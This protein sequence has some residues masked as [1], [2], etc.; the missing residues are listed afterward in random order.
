L[1]IDAAELLIS[2]KEAWKELSPTKSAVG[3]GMGQ[4]LGVSTRNGEIVT[5]HPPCRSY[6][7]KPCAEKAVERHLRAIQQNLDA[8]QSGWV[9]VV[10]EGDFDKDLLRDR[11]YRY[12]LKHPG[13]ARAWYRVVKR[14]DGTR[15][16]LSTVLLGGRLPP[17]SMKPVDDL[18]ASAAEALRLPGVVGFRGSRWPV[19]TGEDGSS[20]LHSF[21]SFTDE[22]KEVFLE[23]VAEEVERRTGVKVDPMHPL[24]YGSD[25]TIDQY[26][27]CGDAVRE[28]G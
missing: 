28:R 2:D 25:I 23:A 20:D 6:G 26:I 15:R 1:A 16:I 27:E 12:R 4:K 14:N 13:D 5:F 9:A 3:C 19:K 17:V 10:D 7:H 8:G 11:L 22:T 24:R 18:L 21:G